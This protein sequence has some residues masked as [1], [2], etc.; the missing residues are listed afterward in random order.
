M[1]I[2][3]ALAQVNPTVGDIT[4]NARQV[5]DTC[6]VAAAGGADLWCFPR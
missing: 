2:R 6:R 3:L 5:I 1:P 4:G